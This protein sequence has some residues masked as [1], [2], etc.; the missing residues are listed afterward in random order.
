MVEELGH[1]IDP[2][3]SQCHSTSHFYQELTQRSLSIPNH[4]TSLRV[5]IERYLAGAPVARRPCGIEESK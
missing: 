5:E 1:G 4:Q 3:V 2:L